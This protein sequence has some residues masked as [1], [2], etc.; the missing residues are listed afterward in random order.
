MTTCVWRSSIVLSD[1]G[2][3]QDG[4]RSTRSGFRHA[5]RSVQAHTTLETVCLHTV[6]TSQQPVEQRPRKSG[7][8]TLFDDWLRRHSSRT[9][10]GLLCIPAASI[11]AVSIA[12]FRR[13]FC[14]LSPRVRV[15]LYEQRTRT[16]AHTRTMLKVG[17]S[18][19]KGRT[20]QSIHMYICM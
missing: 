16:Q 7:R 12:A 1:C 2:S 19:V 15:F 18:C 13:R 6:V 10:R 20:E 9:F 11:A 17:N 4:R 8:L 3:F 14:R 5:V